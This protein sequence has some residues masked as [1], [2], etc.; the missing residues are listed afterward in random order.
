MESGTNDSLIEDEDLVH[1][2]EGVIEACANTGL[3]IKMV[4][5]LLNK[6]GLKD[7][8]VEVGS[9]PDFIH[10]K[11]GVGEED[12]ELLSILT[13]H[14]MQPVGEFVDNLHRFYYY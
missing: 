4:V 12:G 5:D 2:D 3:R 13:L 6:E 10:L 14:V 8:F 1:T 11:E 9:C 7:L